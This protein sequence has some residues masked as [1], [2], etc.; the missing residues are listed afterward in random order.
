M[1]I[2]GVE[3]IAPNKRKHAESIYA[4]VAEQWREDL[5]RHAR[6]GRIHRSH[7][8]WATSRIGL[9]DDRVV[10]H[11]G[12][13]N[14][15]MRIGTARVAT[16]GVNL[17]VTDPDYRKRGLMPATIRASM[18]A[19]RERGYDLSIVCNAIPNYYTRFG[20]VSAWPECDFFVRTRDLPHE[21]P[22]YELRAFNTRHRQELADLYNAENDNITGTAVRPTFLRTKEP[23]DL[24]G[25]TWS[26]ENG[27]LLGYVIY[28]IV[29]NGH[30]VWHYDSA[31]DPDERLRVLAQIARREDADEVRF[32]R[33]PYSSPL[34]VRIR[35]ANCT[36][37]LTYRPTGG[38]M[39]Y[40]VNLKTMF[41]KL[42]GEL[43]RRLSCSELANWR[44]TLVISTGREEVAL[45]INRSHIEVQASEDGE[46]L[47]SKHSLHG[48]EYVAQLVLGSE[49][50]GELIAAHQMQLTG[51]APRLTEI[52]FPAQW[53]QM[54]NADL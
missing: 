49:E 28:D 46:P 35:T 2:E 27:A 37:E 34:A 14:I 50:P 21:P 17:V 45:Q 53:P 39:A 31:G 48:G 16:A 10:A 7:Y 18:A 41:E 6:E 32:N 42:S 26:G 30:A 23:D 22:T 44:G 11:F 1:S 13:Y 54:G 29:S 47:Q 3:I 52:L 15:T 25:Y 38:W 20:Y 4:L 5:R 51:D 33:L 19:M 9:A 36:A 43:S 8:D 40:I 12:V 24:L